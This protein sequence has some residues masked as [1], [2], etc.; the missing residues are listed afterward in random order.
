MAVWQVEEAKTRRIEVNEEADTKG[1]QIITRDGRECATVL[2]I[3]EYKALIAHSPDLKT[4]LL[5]GPK[6]D[7]FEVDRD[8]DMEGR[9]SCRTVALRGRRSLRDLCW[10]SRWC[11]RWSQ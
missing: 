10:A 4:Y 9:L 2:S 1:P 5:Q 3:Q 7:T 8:R 11:S 6:F